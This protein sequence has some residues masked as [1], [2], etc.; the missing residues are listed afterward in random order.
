MKKTAAIF[1]LL[2]YLFNLGGYRLVF[3]YF[4]DESDVVLNQQIHNNHYNTADLVELKIPVKLP[5]IYNWDD[6]H[7]VTGQVQLK[8][9]SYNYVKLKITKDT[10]YLMC[11]PNQVKNSL[12]NAKT[13]YAKTIDDLPAGKSKTES[14]AKKEIDKKY[15]LPIYSYQSNPTLQLACHLP[16]EPHLNNYP[17]IP[18]K[19]NPPERIS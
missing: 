13:I 11:L 15:S 19:E 16:W 5:D 9:H 14:S 6:Y 2:A 3:D 7:S 4:I 17:F 1:L 10:L 8:H 12:V 18:A